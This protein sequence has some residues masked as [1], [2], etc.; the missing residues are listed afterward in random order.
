MVCIEHY[1]EILVAEGCF[2]FLGLRTFDGAAVLSGDGVLYALTPGDA[3]FTVLTPGELDIDSRPDAV[4]LV[5]Y[6]LLR[7]L[8]YSSVGEFTSDEVPSHPGG[9]RFRAPKAVRA[10]AER[11]YHWL[12]ASG[13]DGSSIPGAVGVL[14]S[15]GS[16]QH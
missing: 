8:V 3:S 9:R 13:M 14:S 7:A 16:R 1:E 15:H 12:V 5:V 11:G 4:P 10:S 2:E 6:S